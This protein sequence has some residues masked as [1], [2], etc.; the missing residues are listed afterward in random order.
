MPP[1]TE[2]TAKWQRILRLQDWTIRIVYK[3]HYDM[4]DGKA[5][6]VGWCVKKK[7]AWIDV[8]D[9]QD[10]QPN[11]DLSIPPD[12]ELT[13]VHELLHLQFALVDDLSTGTK[14]DLFEQAIHDI[15]SA[16][17]NLDR[18]RPITA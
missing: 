8:L 13:V 17:V 14:E 6:T 3:R 16:L 5:G 18:A 10:Y 1:L 4:A 2:L 11:P 15:S 7:T 9:P 12:V